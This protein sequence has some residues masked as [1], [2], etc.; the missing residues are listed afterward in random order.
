M[1]SFASDIDIYDENHKNIVNI[2]IYFNVYGPFDDTRIT[3]RFVDVFY[4]MR[5]DPATN[6]PYYLGF[7]KS[8]IR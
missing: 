5:W 3:P 2:Y 7:L 8:V 1:S 6:M 4:T